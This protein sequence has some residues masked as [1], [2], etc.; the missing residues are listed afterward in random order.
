MKELKLS[1]SDLVTIVDDE[2]YERLSLFIWRL[3]KSDRPSV[4]RNNG[5]LK[6]YVPITHDILNCYSGLIDHKDRDILNN[7]KYN[8]RFATD[9]DN[10]ANRTKQKGYY[11][12]KYKGV[13]WRTREGKW[14]VRITC[15]RRTYE[16]GDFTSENEAALAYNKA[17]IEK[18]GEFAVLNTVC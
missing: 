15:N 10:A 1:N 4:V 18:H 16:L 3:H 8:L 12:S 5:R 17:A 2:D 6:P 11:T 14:N 7:Q 9:A 13:S